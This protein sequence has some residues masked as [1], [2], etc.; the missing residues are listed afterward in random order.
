MVR[1]EASL[2]AI[3]RIHEAPLKP[4]G[5]TQALPSIAAV[6][7]CQQVHF[8]AQDAGGRTIEFV[9][10]YG[11]DPDHFARVRAAASAGHLPSWWP[12]VPTG[13]IVRRARMWPDRDFVRSVFYNDVVRP[14]GSF[15]SI[16]ASLMRTPERY[17]QLLAAREKSL[18]D[19]GNEDIAALQLLV[20]HL[21]TAL[22]IS[23]RL[24]TTDLRA[25]KAYA[26]LD[27]LATAVL[28][29]DAQSRILFVN[30]AADTILNTNSGLSARSDGLCTSERHAT[31]VL[32]AL[33]AGCASQTFLDG[34]AGGSIDAPRGPGRE[35]LRILVT[36]FRAVSLASDIAWLS[37][38]P[39][40]ML[41]I[42][43]PEHERHVQKENLR[44][45]FGFTPAEADVALEIVKG[46]GR[47]ATAA[48][49]GISLPT[50][51][52]HLIHIFEKTGVRRQAELVR[53]LL[54]SQCDP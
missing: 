43:D 4:D 33:I 7:G 44:R 24:A 36:P 46:D 26:V 38:H 19:Y 49:L 39:V 20:P 17:V 32:R 31:G 35:P 13:T 28:L 41:M 34:G 22:R 52:T 42:T 48:R 18:E 51:K 1:A 29:V 25:A 54:L 10:G 37:A 14:T 45:R 5:W 50:I 3:E 11:F 9:T 53:L 30:R 47:N 23:D 21:V 27:R 40:A 16:Q 6:L 2:A 12:T 15:H 8:H